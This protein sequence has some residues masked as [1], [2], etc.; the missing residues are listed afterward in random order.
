VEKAGENQIFNI[1]SEA[2]TR[3]TVAAAKD[4]HSV[5]YE[6]CKVLLNG[7]LNVA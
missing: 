2:K 7:Y 1:N 3:V 4:I 5:S 6:K